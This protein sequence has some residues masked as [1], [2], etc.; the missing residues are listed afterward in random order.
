MFSMWHHK[1]HLSSGKRCCATRG[2]TFVVALHNAAPAQ[3][4]SKTCTC[5]KQDCTV[6]ER[7]IP[8]V[9]GRCT[10]CPCSRAIPRCIIRPSCTFCELYNSLC[11]VASASR[12][13]SHPHVT[14]P[15]MQGGHQAQRI[16]SAMQ[17]MRRDKF[18]TAAI[19]Q[20]GAGVTL[21]VRTF[22]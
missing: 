21:S 11:H 12:H 14:R 16:V 4:E 10:R 13:K 9:I 5:C 1:S 22:G 18:G 6:W 17:I 2:I 20:G 15:A 19:V 8:I 7:L 3:M